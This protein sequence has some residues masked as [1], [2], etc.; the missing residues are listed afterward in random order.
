MDIHEY[1]A[2]MGVTFGG[3]MEQKLRGTHLFSLVQ[4]N[5]QTFAQQNP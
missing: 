5:I 2:L 1:L 3:T 4:S